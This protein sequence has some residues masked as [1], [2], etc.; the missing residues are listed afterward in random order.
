M[1]PSLITNVTIPHSAQQLTTLFWLETDP[2]YVPLMRRADGSVEFVQFNEEAGE[3][4][5]ICI[6]LNGNATKSVYD[7]IRGGWDEW[8]LITED[9][10]TVTWEKN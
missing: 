10:D 7:I 9:A 4:E 6:T 3:Y 1:K 8:K 5:E 2:L